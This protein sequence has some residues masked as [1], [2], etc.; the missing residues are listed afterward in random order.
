MCI[1]CEVYIP[2]CI[3]LQLE[4]MRAYTENLQSQTFAHAH[5]LFLWLNIYIKL[6]FCSHLVK[7]NNRKN[8]YKHINYI[9]SLC[10]PVVVSA[11]VESIKTLY[12]SHCSN[13]HLVE[14]IPLLP[15]GDNDSLYNKPTQLFLKRPGM[16]S[17]IP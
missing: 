14:K 11:A 13:E 1:L 4:M 16:T 10:S 5:F 7:T 3:L 9:S 15:F 8:Y 17:P 12:T 6:C 2:V